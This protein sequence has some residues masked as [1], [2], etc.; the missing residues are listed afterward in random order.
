MLRDRKTKFLILLA[1]TAY[2]AVMYALMK[3]FRQVRA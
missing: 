2:T 1:L 3:L